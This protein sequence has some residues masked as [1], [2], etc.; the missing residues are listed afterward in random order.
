MCRA[1]VGSRVWVSTA[2]EP[3]RRVPPSAHRPSGGGEAGGHRRGASAS[4]PRRA[5][6]SRGLR[7][8]PLALSTG[9]RGATAPLRQSLS[10][11]PPT[12]PRATPQVLLYYGNT[13]CFAPGVRYVVAPPSV[14][15]ELQ[16]DR[17]TSASASGKCTPSRWRVSSP[18][19]VRVARET[20]R[21]GALHAPRRRVLFFRGSA[22][23]ISEEA[24]CYQ[25]NRSLAG[26]DATSRCRELYSMGIR[27]AVRQQLG[28]NPIADL[29]VPRPLL[30]PLPPP[31]QS[32]RG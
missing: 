31:E 32:G 23:I 26:A 20:Y 2:P 21:G 6:R 4:A 22:R 14:R 5:T 15:R 7:F 12:P 25:P 11:R 3:R 24:E 9:R 1:R 18:V 29:G 17:C 19:L 8:T 30:R 16:V 10:P 13:D 27:Q 28:A